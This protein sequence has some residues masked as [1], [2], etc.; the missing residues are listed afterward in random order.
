MA[1]FAILPAL[2]GLSLFL[3][4]PAEA[5]SRKKLEAP[6]VPKS[7]RQSLLHSHNDYERA[8]PLL[9]SL[10]ARIDSV[11]ADIWLSDGHLKVAHWNNGDFKGTLKELYLDPLQERVDRL[12]SVHGDGKPFYLWI[13]I[14]DSD[15]ELIPALR[16]LLDGYP[17]LTLFTDGSVAP[18]PVTAILTG[19]RKN[20]KRFVNDYAIRK[21]CR[22]EEYIS[23][24]DPP[25]DHRWQWYALD[26]SS[27]IRWN[28]Y[29]DMPAEDRAWLQSWVNLAHN[30]GR[31]L[32]IW[33]APDDRQ[34][35]NEMLAAGVD[36]IGADDIADL[37]EF[38]EM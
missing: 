28:G 1:S 36:L 35:W 31:R 32:R 24:K 26:W 7:E 33:N 15:R 18:G 30:K 3:A 21:A 11:E 12:G 27:Q 37:R 20:K 9:D 25:A 22:D 8:R 34:V 14:K 17:M 16:E 23:E 38:V 6:T 4:Q 2:L 10:S 13:D 19:D 29:G 5:F